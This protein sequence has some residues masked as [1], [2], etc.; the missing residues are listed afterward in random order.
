MFA[1][2]YRPL[3][4]TALIGTAGPMFAEPLTLAPVTLTEWKAVYGRIEA[5]NRIPARARLGG[6]LTELAVA[7]GDQVTAGQVLGKIVD[8]KLAFQLSAIDA[9]LASV[10]AQ[11]ANAKAELQRGED[12]LKQGVTTVQ[13]LDALRTQVDVLAGQIASV[14]AQRKVVEQQAA[15][16][17]VLAPA[18]GRV[19]Q[20]PVAQGAVVMPGEAVATLGGGGIFLRLAVPERHAA[21]LHAGDAIEIEA[22]DGTVTG[23]LARV[24]PL[25]ENGRV[26]A[27]VEVAG[28]P[29]T[30]VDARVLV[31]LPV[32]THQALMVPQTAVVTRQGLDFVLVNGDLRAVVP[33]QAQNVDGVAMVEILSGLQAGDVIETTGVA[34]D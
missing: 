14:A 5:R 12:L 8:E 26:V 4:V 7:E 16:G 17:A 21:S 31:R 6:T 11:L 22:A 13:R 25:I 24:Y 15:E 34:H 19:L 27:D 30:F 32:A 10:T 23:T 2:L 1:A 33:G 9:Q 3:L 18:T 20:V 28:L 29:D